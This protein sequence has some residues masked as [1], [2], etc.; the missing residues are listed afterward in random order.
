V[1]SRRRLRFKVSGN[2]SRAFLASPVRLASVREIVIDRYFLGRYKNAQRK[3]SH[4]AVLENRETMAFPTGLN[5]VRH[6]QWRP[7]V[8]WARGRFLLARLCLLYKLYR[9]VG[10]E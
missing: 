3:D 9:L 10:I 1:T 6:G 5:I 8:Q 7:P 4:R 2:S